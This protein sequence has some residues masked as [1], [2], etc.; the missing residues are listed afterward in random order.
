MFCCQLRKDVFLA[1]SAF[2]DSSCHKH[3]L[4]IAVTLN[5]C[6]YSIKFS[7]LR[8]WLTR[9]NIKFVQLLSIFI[10]LSTMCMTLIYTDGPRRIRISYYHMLFRLRDQY[11]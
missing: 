1:K 7:I 10:L 2:I 5:V 4:E 8:A 6:S 9:T 11:D 3:F